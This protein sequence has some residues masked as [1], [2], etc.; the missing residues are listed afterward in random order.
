[1]KSFE[2]AKHPC[3]LS[4]ARNRTQIRFKTEHHQHCLS[5]L[6]VAAP[7]RLNKWNRKRVPNAAALHL[8]SHFEALTFEALTFE[9]LTFE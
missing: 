8:S 6:S 4:A 9:A 3:E 1:M 2:C 7:S 5:L